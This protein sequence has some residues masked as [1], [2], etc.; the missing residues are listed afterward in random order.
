MPTFNERFKRELSKPSTNR[1]FG[2]YIEQRD[3]VFIIY[4]K[5]QET[6]QNDT[7]RFYPYRHNP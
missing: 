5:P 4:T 6:K 3:D 7:A 1:K 2:K